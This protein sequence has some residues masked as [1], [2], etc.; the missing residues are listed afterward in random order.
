MA[1]DELPINNFHFSIYYMFE[2]K[3][4]HVFEYL[5]YYTGLEVKPGYAVLLRGKWGTGKTWLI[6]NFIGESSNK[7]FLFVSLNGVNSYK[8][9]DDSFFQR[10]HPFWPQ[11][12]EIGWKNIQRYTKDY[13]LRV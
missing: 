13:K 10:L 5:N 11:G 4:H 1:F 8:E 7:E 2:K 3:N 6:K 12:Y 9:I